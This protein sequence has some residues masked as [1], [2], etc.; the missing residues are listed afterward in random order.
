MICLLPN[1]AF[2]SE[3]TR[4]LEI[5]RALRERDAAVRV[6]THGGTYEYLLA[7]AGVPYDVIGPRMTP[8]RCAQFLR[9]EIGMGN[10]NQSTYTDDELRTYARAEADYFRTHGIRV[11]VTGFTLTTVLSTRLAGVRLVTEHNGS[12][13]PPVWEHGLLPA[14]ARPIRPAFRALPDR[15]VRWL[16]NAAPPR[17]RFYTSGFNRIATELG[18]PQVPSLAALVLGDLTLVTEAPE[19]I[20]IPPQVMERWRPDGR[21][22]YRPSMR[23][24]YTGPLYT[25]LDRPLPDR[26]ARF[27][28]QDGPMIY[29]AITSS[30]PHLVRAAVRALAPLDARILVAGT[31]HDLGDLAG[32]RVLVDGVLPSHRVMPRVDLA[33][34]A[35]GQ[36]SMQ[37]AMAAGTPVLG[38]PLQPEQDLNIVLLE[39][40]GAARRLA[41]RHAGTDRLT[42]MARS[43]LADGAY[44]RA[45]GAVK[46]AYDGIDGPANAAAAIVEFA[47]RG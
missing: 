41:L 12:W 10:V 35:G 42:A 21:R 4:L 14:P 47:D 24:R 6:A 5:Y 2:L 37:T 40:L 18:V 46:R 45:A 13:V 23:L 3:T 36:G 29:V 26:V 15:V 43:M 16:T 34:T 27:L 19:V 20:G 28:D 9:D 39:R 8:E 33:V 17:V 25:R 32:E 31:V 7:E 22:G 30:P 1:C 38:L 11:A 44:R